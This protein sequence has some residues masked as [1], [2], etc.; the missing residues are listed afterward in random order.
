MAEHVPGAID[1][2][3]RQLCKL[4]S[5]RGAN[6]SLILKALAVVGID[7][8]N[9]WD[10]RKAL[11]ASSTILTTRIDLPLV[12]GGSFSWVVARPQELLPYCYRECHGFR[13]IMDETLS[14]QPAALAKPW[15]LILYCDEITPGDPLRPDNKR[16]L[17]AFY[18]SW[19]ELGPFLRYE[20]AWLTIG[21]LR[22]SIVKHIAGRFSGAVRCLLRSMFMCADS[23][24]TSGALVGGALFFCRYHRMIMDEAAGKSVWMVKGASGIRSCISCKNVVKLGSADDP[25]LASFDADGYLVD[26]SCCDDSKFD[27]MVEGDL[28]RAFDE[29]S[30]LRTAPGITKAMFGKA[31]KAYGIAFDPHCLLADVPMRTLVTDV[32]YTRDPMHV[33]LSGG[34]ANTELFLVLQAVQSCFPLFR[35]ST[36]KEFCNAAWTSPG[37]RKTLSEAFSDGREAASKKD[38]MFKGS[39]SEILSVYPLVRRFLETL[40]PSDAIPKQKSSFFAMCAVL[41]SMQ[42]CKVAFD[43]GLPV[44]M[45]LE[46]RNFF[47]LHLEAYG[48]RHI[49]PKHHYM[50]HMLRQPT[51]DKIWLDCFVHERKHQLTKGLA[52]VV[53]NTSDFEKSVL[54]AV[55]NATVENLRT[56]SASMLVPPVAESNELTIA[57]GMRCLVSHSMKWNFTTYS[58]G[59]VLMVGNGGLMIEACLE[60]GGNL[61]AL[62]RRLVFI[63]QLSSTASTWR[64]AEQVVVE[65]HGVFRPAQHWHK[66]SAGDLVVLA[67]KESL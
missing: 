59:D 62:A 37:T 48:R 31:E 67:A 35:Y 49:R 36:M 30:A 40:V 44:A 38:E 2:K 47:R 65:M 64:V 53:R 43:E 46:I 56:V 7:D 16:K 17:S 52:E 24:H 66:N 18:I 57:L 51:E 3:R 34:V 61:L 28:A 63:N 45:R 39:A 6:A 14:R 60:V 20:E 8:L 23:L 58:S 10:L 32:S 11:A 15:R 19:L 55:L 4:L 29:L 26:I 12:K 25:S 1:G 54:L 41:D 50:F 9:R 5:L 22:P 27:E 13:I 33:M 42:A 21:I